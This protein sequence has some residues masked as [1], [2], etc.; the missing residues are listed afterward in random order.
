MVV[1]VWLSQNTLS[2]L[3]NILTTVATVPPWNVSGPGYKE[4][5]KQ[6]EIGFLS[7]PSHSLDTI[8]SIS[9][10]HVP[11]RQNPWPSKKVVDNSVEYASEG[12]H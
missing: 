12:R 8:A 7:L 1:E 4:L 10:E 5:L 9:L 6:F 11:L 3:V 2:L